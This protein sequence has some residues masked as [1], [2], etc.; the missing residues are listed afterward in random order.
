MQLNRRMDRRGNY[1]SES[2]VS[3]ED[4]AWLHN[5]RAEW[6]TVPDADIAEAKKRILTAFG[7]GDRVHTVKGMPCRDFIYLASLDHSEHYFVC[8]DP[9]QPATALKYD[10]ECDMYF[11]P[12]CNFSTVL[13][14]RDD[15]TAETR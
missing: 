8:T 10:G 13:L 4:Q 1:W 2:S 3:S 5:A 7:F 6:E 9:A 15:G 11:A 14:Q 12:D